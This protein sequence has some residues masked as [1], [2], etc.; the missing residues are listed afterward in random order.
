MKKKIL[1]LALFGDPTLPAGIANTGGFNQTLREFLSAMAAFNLPICVITDTSPYHQDRYA[2]ISDEIELFRVF[3]GQE[4]HV[5]QEK[6]RDS[7][8]R[9]L[10]EIYDILG[11]DITNIAMIHSF[12]W[13]SGHLARRMKDERNISYIHTP[14]SL[15]YNKISAGHSVVCPFQVECERAF[16]P[17]ADLILAITVQEA[18]ILSE[19][20]QIDE[21]SIVVTGRSVDAVFHTPARDDNGVPRNTVWLDKLPDISKDAPWWTAGAFLY[22]GRMVPIKGVVQIIQAWDA[23]RK[24]YGRETPPLWLVGGSVAQI[25]DLRRKILESVHDLPLYET[26]HEVVWWGYL[27]QASISALFLKTLALVTH[28]LFE[29]GGRVVLEAMCQGRPVIAT[30]NGFAAD[31]VQD[32][33]NG[34]LVPY[35]DY[36]RLSRCMEYFVRQPYLAC[37]MGHAAR[38]TFQQIER[39]WN[40]V[41]IHRVVYE[42][43]LIGAPAVKKTGL[44]KLSVRF[45]G[46]LTEKVAH[47]PYMDTKFS[48]AEWRRL[49]SF[50]FQLPITK[51]EAVPAPEYNA[52]HYV[53]EAGEARF[54]I[55]QFYNRLNLDAI[56]NGSEMSKVYTATEQMRRATQSQ[57]LQGIIPLIRCSEAG[58][59]YIL[60]ELEHGNLDPEALYSLLDTFSAS[61]Q[62]PAQEQQAGNS[63][64]VSAP[65]GTLSFTI[66][67][68][69]TSSHMLGSA[70]FQGLLAVVPQIRSIEEESR[71]EAIWGF[72]YGKPLSGHVLLKDGRPVLLPTS[73][74]YFGELGPDY[75]HAAL[76][77]GQKI[78]ALPGQSSEVRQRLWLL[79]AAWRKLLQMEWRGT[80]LSPLW[81]DRLS[82]ALTALKL[83]ARTVIP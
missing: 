54:R 24:K 28:S 68:L 57:Q 13:F 51:F 31:Y 23:L 26:Q 22:I 64:S 39:D 59:Y 62:L 7:Q 71:T 45:T 79:A 42:H 14:I 47:F 8:D 30:P 56:W 61:P 5:N 81:T 53:F 12:Y 40:Y 75:I 60:Q 82:Q 72:N 21:Q 38:Y 44:R 37:A 76:W 41:G 27:D 73:R 16:L 19:Q 55:K 18:K 50:Q 66:E 63:G 3:I 52:H 6:L 74:W 58:S 17:E 33:A 80:A 49:L 46:E 4:D 10:S 36:G 34:F 29:P 65:T 35:G 11:T 25:S 9:I 1:I 83:D 69:A 67:T 15:A 48:E 2:R 32:W 77:M 20:Y 78:R 43:Y 70:R